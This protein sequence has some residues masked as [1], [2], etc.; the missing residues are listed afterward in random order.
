MAAEMEKSPTSQSPYVIE[1]FICECP[2]LIKFSNVQYQERTA[3][4]NLRKVAEPVFCVDFDENF[5]R[6]QGV[7]LQPQESEAATIIG[8]TTGGGAHPVS[9]HRIDLV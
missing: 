3:P 1:R 8:E 2:S 4:T 7:H 5:C 9:G 6:C